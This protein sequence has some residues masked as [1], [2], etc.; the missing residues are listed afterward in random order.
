MRGIKMAKGR[1]S[2]KMLLATIIA[3]VIYSVIAEIFYRVAENAMPGLVLIPLYFTGL[4]LVLGGTVLLTGKMIYRRSAGTVN[5]KQWL[6]ALLLIVVLSV[7]FEFLYE[8]V[9]DRR[10]NEEITAYLFV[11]DDSGSMEVNDPDRVR[12]QVIDTLR[13]T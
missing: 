6:I 1:Y 3:G 13:W 2:I 4:F 11:L 8:I 7:F 10:K 5:K 12:Y 9:S